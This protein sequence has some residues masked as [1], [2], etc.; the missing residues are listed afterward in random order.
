MKLL[1]IVSRWSCYCSFL[2]IGGGRSPPPPSHSS[3]DLISHSSFHSSAFV[4][5]WSSQLS[6]PA[7]SRFQADLH[8]TIPNGD[9][10]RAFFQPK[11]LCPSAILLQR[12]RWVNPRGSGCPH[13]FFWKRCTE[14]GK[15]RFW[16]RRHRPVSFPIVFHFLWLLLLLRTW[17]RPLFIFGDAHRRTWTRECGEPTFLYP[18]AFLFTTA[19]PYS[20]ASPLLFVHRTQLKL[21]RGPRL[22]FY[23]K[24]MTSDFF[25]SVFYCP[26]VSEM[27]HKAALLWALLFMI[28]CLRASCPPGCECDEQNK[29]VT[30]REVRLG[31]IPVFLNP[32]LRILRLI[33]C[34]VSQPDSTTLRLY[35]GKAI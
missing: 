13:S 31:F 11:T 1:F 19:F 25:N 4:V 23:I 6:A 2:V 26:C 32:E 22:P 30:C 34:S 5:R 15:K 29:E 33:N 24:F 21:I 10:W 16:S 27:R 17:P 3:S 28:P 7:D 14:A 8:W 18:T 9:V 35:E 12:Q 20:T